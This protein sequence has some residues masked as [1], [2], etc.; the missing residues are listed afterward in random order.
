MSPNL[1]ANVRRAI[2]IIT[3]GSRQTTDQELL[4]AFDA[5]AIGKEEAG[6]ILLFLPIAACRR[7]LPTVCWI[8]NYQELD[9]KSGKM[10]RRNFSETP[11]YQAILSEVGRY[12]GTQPGSDNILKLAARSSEFH[13]INNML[14]KGWKLDDI[15]VTPLAILL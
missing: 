3:E 11:A 15:G 10:I 13:V 9:R 8:D 6:M 14:N 4:D 2:S 1:M 5:A 12:F 7:M